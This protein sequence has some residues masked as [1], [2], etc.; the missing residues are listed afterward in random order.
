VTLLL[1]IATPLAGRT[2]PLA[3]RPVV[4]QDYVAALA[5]AN[6]FLQA[7][8]SQDQETGTLLLSDKVKHRIAEEQ[9]QSLFSRPA[10]TQEAYEIGAG[11]K[12]KS[13]RYIFFVVLF[14][15]R[16]RNRHSSR[17][18]VTRIGKNDWVVDKLP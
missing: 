5:T 9:L 2:R 10:K 6:R 15:S 16:N 7:W 12:L 14:N 1:T 8:Q 3:G 17:M 18:I 4:D 13:G 11:K